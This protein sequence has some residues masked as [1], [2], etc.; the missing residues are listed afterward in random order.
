V[1]DGLRRMLR[2]LRREWEMEFAPGGPEALE[3]L[4]RRPC[5]V[6]VSDMRMPG[7]DGAQLLGEVLNHHPSTVRMILSG[8]CDRAAVMKAV[9]PAHQFLSKPC[10]AEMCVASLPSL[11]DVYHA[12]REELS[13]EN[14]SP[15]AIGRLVDADPALTARLL[16]LVSSSFFGSSR[17]VA[18]A[19]EAAELLG[20]ET[21]RGL[22]EQTE[23]FRPA[24][25]WWNTAARWPRPLRPSPRPNPTTNA[26]RPTRFWP[27]GS[28]RPAHW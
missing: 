21:L 3:L 6:V 20:V 9:G 25:P 10:D 26:W 2:K 18:S 15:A 8:Q 7:M 5:D 11:P 1:L 17:R 19:A 12:L 27:V 16:Q 13:H 4:D 24:E 23:V 14:P 22:F 28:T